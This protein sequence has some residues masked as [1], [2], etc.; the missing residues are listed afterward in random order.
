MLQVAQDALDPE[1]VDIPGLSLQDLPEALR[2]AFGLPSGSDGLILDIFTDPDTSERLL[3]LDFSLQEAVSTAIGLDADLASLGVPDLANLTSGGVLRAI[4]NLDLNVTLGIE[5]DKANPEIYVFDIADP[6]R[7]LLGGSLNVSGEELVFRAAL[8]P[9][10]VFIRDGD[11]LFDLDPFKLPGFDFGGDDRKLIGSIDLNTDLEA[12]T[13][14]SNIDVVLPMFFP[15]ES[16]LNFIGEFRASGQIGNVSID[17]VPD[18]GDVIADLGDFD[19][20]DNILLAIDTV[21]F[22]LEGLQD[23]L[24]ASL[25]IDL[26]FIGDK[27]A[28]GTRFI[29]S[30]R[31][32]VVRD[33]RDEVE[34]AINPDADQVKQLLFDL[35]TELDLLK[36][37]TGDGL[38]LDDILVTSTGLGTPD[39]SDDQI[40]WDVKLGDTFFAPAGVA[41]DFGVPALGFA[42]DLGVE[43]RVRLGARLRLRRQLH[44][45]GLHRRVLGRVS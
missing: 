31:D 18:I 40:Q 44:G 30:F 23:L 26:P 43:L 34:A 29:E 28:D 33:I 14:S 13:Q 3:T 15:T 38:D 7:P 11:A 21:D 27:L 39:F 4:G 17:A 24:D 41:F 2:G 42:A 6:L 12:S 9:L 22:G 36:D 1:N 37:Q 20:F 8:G 16:P 10:G 19:V 35:F 32:R 5:L 25:G 45:G